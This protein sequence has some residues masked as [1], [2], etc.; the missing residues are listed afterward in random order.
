MTELSQNSKSHKST[1][2]N[3]RQLHLLYVYRAVRHPKTGQVLKTCAANDVAVP[4]TAMDGVDAERS[5]LFQQ[6]LRL[7]S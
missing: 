4:E 3:K 2:E 7:F 5:F 6:L 1:P